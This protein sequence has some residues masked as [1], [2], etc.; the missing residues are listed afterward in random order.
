M[1]KQ[2]SSVRRDRIRRAPF[3]TGPEIAFT[4]T[5]IDVASSVDSRPDTGGMTRKP[6]SRDKTTTLAL[7]ETGMNLADED[8]ERLTDSESIS[9]RAQVFNSKTV[10][11]VNPKSLGP[12]E[13]GLANTSRLRQAPS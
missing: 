1:G 3:I 10:K 11:D 9:Q 12:L 13:W 2:S 4:S 5:S 8:L 6:H 7:A